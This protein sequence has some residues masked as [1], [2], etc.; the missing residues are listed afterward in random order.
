LNPDPAGRAIGFWET[1]ARIW[2]T[3]GVPGLY[4]GC[5]LTVA[6]AAPS[7]AMIF[8]IYNTLEKKLGWWFE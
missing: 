8:L 3:R 5:G 6:R 4:A 7:S 1:A 2:R